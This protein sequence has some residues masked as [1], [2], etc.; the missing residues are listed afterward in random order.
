MSKFKIG[1]LPKNKKGKK[2]SLGNWK[3]DKTNKMKPKE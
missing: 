2:H 1:K 3:R